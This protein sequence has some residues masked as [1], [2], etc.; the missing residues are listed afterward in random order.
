VLLI[1][2]LLFFHVRCASFLG[3]L[4]QAQN[5]VP[6]LILTRG[7]RVLSNQVALLVLRARVFTLIRRRGEVKHGVP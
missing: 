1:A 5:G 3:R 7:T 2:L 4:G 6:T